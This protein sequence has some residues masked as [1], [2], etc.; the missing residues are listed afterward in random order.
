MFYLFLILEKINIH[1]YST[2]KKIEF[3]LKYGKKIKIGKK[4]IFRKPIIIRIEKNGYLEIGN[5]NFFNSFASLN[6]LNYIKI[7]NNNRF[8]E[9]IHIYD[10]NHKISNTNWNTYT[11]SEI[12][13]GNHNWIGTNSILLKGSSLGNN[14]V[15]GAGSILNK[16]IEN[17]MIYFNGKLDK[18]MERINDKF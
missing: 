7:G 18:K 15:I 14:N 3:R 5:D 4:V 6:V 11:M 12:I 9:N 16:K 1:I 10:H 13:I 2:L 8:G 17:D